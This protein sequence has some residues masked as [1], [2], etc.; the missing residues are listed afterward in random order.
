MVPPDGVHS[1]RSHVVPLDVERSDDPTRSCKTWCWSVLTVSHNLPEYAPFNKWCRR[2]EF[3]PPAARSQFECSYL[4]F[5]LEYCWLAFAPFNKW[6]RRMEF[7]VL[8]V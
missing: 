6:C 4:N 3:S 2:M 8:S 1:A 5:S 7:L